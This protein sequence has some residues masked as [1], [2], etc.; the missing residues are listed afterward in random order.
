MGSQVTSD[1]WA[2]AEQKAIAFTPKATAMLSLVGSVSILG[3]I[4]RRLQRGEESRQ[5][6]RI[7]LMMSMFDFIGSAWFFASTW[8][9]PS[10][11]KN[12]Y[13]AIGTVGSCTTQGFFLQFNLAVPFYYTFLSVNYV[14]SIKY[15]WREHQLRK[16]EPYMHAAAILFPLATATAAIP[17]DLY[18]AAGMWCWIAKYPLTCT[19]TQYATT[20]LPAS[21]E[22]GNNAAIYQWSF[23]YAPL[24]ALMIVALVAMF[25]VYRHV[26]RQEKRISRFIDATRSGRASF[27]KSKLVAVQGGLY[28]AC[29]YLTWI[30]GTINRLYQT[31]T[32]KSNF[33]L[34]F[35][36]SLF[37]PLQGFLNFFVYIRPRFYAHVANEGNNKS[38]GMRLL[39]L[40]ECPCC[41]HG[42]A[43]N[44]SFTSRRSGDEEPEPSPVGGA[45]R[46]AS[47][48]N[49]GGLPHT[50][51]G[52]GGMSRNVDFA[53]GPYSTGNAATTSNGN[54]SSSVQEIIR[55]VD[56]I[57]RRQEKE[58]STTESVTPVSAPTP[59]LSAAEDDIAGNEGVENADLGASA[60]ENKDLG[61][62]AVENEVGDKDTRFTKLQDENDNGK[63]GKDT[64]GGISYEAAN[65]GPSSHARNGSAAVQVEA[66]RNGAAPRAA[67]D[68]DVVVDDDNDD[69]DADTG[70]DSPDT[71][72]EC[73]FVL[74]AEA[75]DEAKAEAANKDSDAAAS[76]REA[77]S[78][79]ASSDGY[80]NA[81][82][83]VQ[84]V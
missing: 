4:T 16:I 30:F 60:V 77:R 51:S 52:R 55:S 68:D 59:V 35:L 79:G 45:G 23:F 66:A 69:G 49:G 84:L 74:E 61:A 13:G 40:F 2:I 6:H 65:G 5:Y 31:G 18:N 29:F 33:A 76:P 83:T 48:K 82:T 19:S 75:E 8:P 11:T 14:L 7:L 64:E 78:H 73:N 43:P 54:S 17:L 1:M 50:S 70:S 41:P 22:R 24:W 39:T 53:Q 34:T 57:S 38:W 26:W 27:K 44:R 47:A 36:H 72:A 37:V 46:R 15:E 12:V 71:D 28:V 63:R 58:A 56:V 81:T 67:G 20:E 21:C 25:M 42:E 9:M 80:A 10:D 32:G 62:S 3:S